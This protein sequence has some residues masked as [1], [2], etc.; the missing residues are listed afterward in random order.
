MSFACLGSG[1]TAHEKTAGRVAR[2]ED[3]INSLD[4]IEPPDAMKSEHSS[5]RQ[6]GM[7]YLIAIR[8]VEQIRPVAS[9]TAASVFPSTWSQMLATDR[10]YRCDGS[11]DFWGYG[12]SMHSAPDVI[13]DFQREC[14]AEDESRALLRSHMARLYAEINID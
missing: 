11:E 12:N 5:L 9:A 10:F 7:N 8:R 4:S 1:K 6:L 2:C 13:Y 3:Q 14:L